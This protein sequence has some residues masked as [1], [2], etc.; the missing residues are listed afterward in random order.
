MGEAFS[1][2]SGCIFNISDSGHLSIGDNVFM[3]DRCCVN[4]RE[5]VTIGSGC[6]FGQ[7]VMIYDHDHDYRGDLRNGFISAPVTIGENTW[8]GSGAIILKGVHIGSGCVIAANS[9]VTRDV[10]DDTLYRNDIKPLL[11]HI[12]R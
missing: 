3:N 2:R 8:I 11:K 10:P 6:L 12:V 1:A 7:N 9:V 4:V 5:D